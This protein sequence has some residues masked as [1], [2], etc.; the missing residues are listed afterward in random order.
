MRQPKPDQAPESE[1]HSDQMQDLIG[2][3]LVS[4]QVIMKK[5]LDHRGL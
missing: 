5:T 3:V 2:T 1:G 4:Q